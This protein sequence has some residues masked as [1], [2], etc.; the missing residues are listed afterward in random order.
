MWSR[1][2]WLAA[3]VV[4]AA[5]GVLVW[6]FSP[7]APKPAE[8]ESIDGLVY[9]SPGGVGLKIDLVVPRGE[10]PYPAIVCLHGGGWT[11]G[12]RKEM[13]QTMAVLGRRGFV[14]A[15]PDV[16]LAPKHRFPAC[17]EDARAAVRW[18]R[19]NASSYKVDPRRIG[20]MGLSTG[21]HLAL[22]LAASTP[23]ELQCVAGFSAPVDLASAEMH[24]PAL[25]EHNLVPLLGAG[26]KEAPEAYR[27]AS[28]IHYDL[29]GMPVVFLA[30]GS[31]DNL[32]PL[33][34]AQKFRH[35]VGEAGG[36][37]KLMVL[38]GE[39]H[40]WRGANLLRSI[41]RMLTFLDE[42]LKR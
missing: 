26:P 41:D 19:E 40:T 21:G 11:T 37:V 7:G 22:L 27:K 20:V 16:R 33:A 15:A 23:G 18:L 36:T 6:A 28:P 4:V 12:S 39:G 38:E 10:G 32:I 3:L 14:A 17:L 9:A 31:E 29:K 1:L 30:H 25:L 42:S 13:A 34:H 2:T 24:T 5:V 35:Q 8:G